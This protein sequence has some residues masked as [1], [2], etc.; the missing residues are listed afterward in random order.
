QEGEKVLQL[1]NMRKKD[2]AMRYG[3][4]NY[5]ILTRH[6]QIP[7]DGEGAPSNNNMLI[8]GS[9]GTYKT[10]SVLTPNLLLAQNN[11]ILL[12]V[13]G[14]LMYK[15]GLFL[16]SRGY[17]IRCLNLKDQMKSDRYNPF[18]YIETEL[19][20]IKLVANIYDAVTPQGPTASDPFWTDGP[21]LYLQA[22]F[23]YEWTMAKRDGRV[24][25]MNNIL[26]IINEE[27]IPDKTAKVK[28]G[29]K[30]PSILQ[31]KMDELAK[32]E[33]ELTPAVRDYRKFK[34]GA[35]ETVRSIIIIVNAKLKLCE[36]QGLARIFEDD[37]LN[38]REFA[39]GVGGTVKN[40]SG[41]KMALFLCVNDSDESFNYVCSMLYTQ[42]IEILSRMADV[43][44]RDRGGALPIPLEFWMD[45]F[46]AGA[47][48]HDTE[49]LM[50]VIRSRNISM[51]PILQSV[52]Q[53]KVVFDAEKWEVLMD[54]CPTMVFLGSGAGASDTHKY[55]SDL[56]G[57][58]TIDTAGDGRNGQ[59]YSSNYNRAGRELM[60]PAEVKRMNRKHAIV[61][62]EEERPVYDRK[63]LP[64]E[65]P[66]RECNFKEA[67]KL[68]KKSP[69]GGYEHPVQV[70]I[71]PKT[72]EYLTVDSTLDS[73]PMR[74]VRHEDVPEDATVVEMSED[75]FLNQNL[76]NR[77]C[78]D[79]VREYYMGYMGEVR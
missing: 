30:P 51:I 2:P 45:E 71:D 10:T 25:T 40:P 43:D 3:G 27:M 57:K 33:G 60:T 11:Y 59:N 41:K 4:R 34:A 77:D 9:S 58:M 70:E 19:D 12:D 22:I 1:M 18:A 7:M 6:L 44:F 8:I 16:Q 69:T 66:T 36:T 73:R 72:G 61:F 35:A 56:L 24:G 29:E 49:K 21:M 31:R 74:A 28:K 68:N 65:M 75:E 62:L 38:L 14:E 39:T 53:I 23:F 13:K 79:Q 67:M 26:K 64:W 46:Y 32:R 17:T 37:D 5:R 15:Y 48:P 54:N 47:R 76:K 42:A 78:V 50:G 20:L 63:A 55:I 52:A